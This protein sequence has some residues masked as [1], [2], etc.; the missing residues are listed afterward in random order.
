M[1]KIDRVLTTIFNLE[2]NNSE[3]SSIRET[4]S[5]HTRSPSNPTEILKTKLPKLELKTFDG[6]ILNWQQ[7]WD[8]F[9]SS[10]DS[11]SNINSVD[12]FAYLQ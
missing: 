7:F 12:K 8:R 6:S 1:T 4:S 2:R 10:I 11:N 3:H 5:N 9:Q